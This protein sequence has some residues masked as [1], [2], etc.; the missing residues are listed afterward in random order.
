[1]IKYGKIENGEVE[2]LK[3]PKDKLCVSENWIKEQGY[4]KVIKQEGEGGI[5]EDDEFIYIETPASLSEN[6]II[7]LQR[8]MA[9][10]T[11]SDP[12]FMAYVK[13][14]HLQKS[15]KAAN[16]K[17]QWLDKV[18]EIDERFPYIKE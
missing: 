17:Q 9:Y 5:Y 18:A 11:E 2:Y 8:K 13:N 10:E 15:D 12:L 7:E 14:E 1:M 3:K 4:K 16:Y 6:E